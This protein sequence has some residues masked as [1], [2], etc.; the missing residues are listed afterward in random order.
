VRFHALAVS[1][2]ASAVAV[3]YWLD[4]AP[5]VRT[6]ALPDLAPDE[7]LAGFTN[8]VTLS[9]TGD[10]SLLLTQGAGDL[11]LYDT[12]T[13]EVSRRLT[14]AGTIA[15]NATISADG[16]H[17]AA[18]INFSVMS[19][20]P[21]LYLWSLP[22][23]SE[24][25]SWIRDFNRLCDGLAFR[26]N[27]LYLV[28]TDGI[29]Q[30]ERT[31]RMDPQLVIALENSYTSNATFGGGRVAFG[32]GGVGVHIHDLEFQQLGPIVIL[33][34]DDEVSG[35]FGSIPLALSTDRTLLARRAGPE[36]LSIALHQLEGDQMTLLPA[37]ARVDAL[38][39]TAD[40]AYLATGYM[41]GLI[42]IWDL[43]TGEPIARLGGSDGGINALLFTADGRT[44][45][46]TADDGVVRVWDGPAVWNPNDS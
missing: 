40:S 1:P 18:C 22:E 34:N 38:A 7:P 6:L 23:S 27:R 41:D 31:N 26:E 28:A 32:V 11:L 39:F 46:S 8:S 25:I 29:F 15:L 20:E 17:A 43:A 30:L 5:V 13:G 37:P 3:R 2:D 42:Q 10:E 4:D 44:L 9:L 35:G 24:G 33:P 21:E 12:A 19:Y 36:G 45:Y 14:H 16:V